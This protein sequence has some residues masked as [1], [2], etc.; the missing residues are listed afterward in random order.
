MSHKKRRHE[1]DA[2][3]VRALERLT[4]QN[5]GSSDL[6]SQSLRLAKENA[7]LRRV[8]V[9]LTSELRQAKERTGGNTG[10]IRLTS[11]AASPRT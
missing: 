5:G 1:P 3:V 7:H 2:I 10:A 11:L 8:I 4:T 9:E 6:K